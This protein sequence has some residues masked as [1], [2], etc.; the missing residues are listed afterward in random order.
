MNVGGCGYQRVQSE[1][2]PRLIKGQRE[3]QSIANSQGQSEQYRGHDLAEA[4][5]GHQPLPLQKNIYTTKFLPF[6]SN[7][8]HASMHRRYQ[9]QF[10]F[11]N[12]GIPHINR[13]KQ[14]WLCHKSAWLCRDST[15]IID[16]LSGLYYQ[17]AQK[18]PMLSHQQPQTFDVFLDVAA[19]LA[20]ARCMR[21]EKH[22][23]GVPGVSN[24]SLW[25]T[26]MATDKPACLPPQRASAIHMRG[27]R[28]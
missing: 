6:L 4:N 9:Y 11:W 7:L 10:K 21:C 2:C 14:A 16:Q 25:I 22:R 20:I 15:M 5:E 3:Y 26:G 24:N 18:M 12:W 19:C 13:I 1:S 8:F 23:G 28:R 17:K 27:T